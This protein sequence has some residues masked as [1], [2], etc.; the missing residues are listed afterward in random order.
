MIDWTSALTGSAPTHFVVELGSD[1]G[2][3]TLPT[4]SVAWPTTELAL[5]LPAGTYYTRVRAVNGAGT[6]PPSPEASVVVTEPSPIPGPPG[7]FF[8]RTIGRTASF[9]W[10]ASTEGAAATSYT[11]EAGSAPGRAD[12]AQLVTGTSETSLDVPNVPAGTYW[13]R[14]RGSNAAGIGAPSHDISILMGSGSGCVGLAGTPVLLTPVVSGTNVSLNWNPPALGGWPTSYVLMAGSAAGG[15][16]LAHFNTGSAATA[17][18][19]SAPPGLYYV[20]VAA[21]NACGIGP[22]SN[23]VTFTLGADLPGAPTSLASTVADGGVV[24]L[25]WNPPLSGAPPTAYVVEAGSASGLSDLATV[26]TGAPVTTF[27]ATAPPGAYYVRVRAVNGA[28]AGLPSAD[29]LVIVP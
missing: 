1:V 2:M 6:S 10:T 4:Q 13:V 14:V 24:S 21:A 23:E 8:A 19:G 3:T 12:L 17:F 22:A 27:T 29:V 7:N 16:N 28:G 11:I 18:A 20:R 25:S 15:S 26:S 9:T 5:T